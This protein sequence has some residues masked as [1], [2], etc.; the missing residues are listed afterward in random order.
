MLPAPILFDQFHETLSFY[1]F[2]IDKLV[3]LHAQPPLWMF[4]DKI[5]AEFSRFLVIVFRL[6]LV[7]H[8]P[9]SYSS[10]KSNAA[11][12]TATDYFGIVRADGG[13]EGPHSCRNGNG[14]HQSPACGIAAP[15]V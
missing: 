7:A 8:S 12:G 3:Q 11:F 10:A 4:G 1:V 14:R 13:G 5:Q 2:H 6:D 15:D 9:R